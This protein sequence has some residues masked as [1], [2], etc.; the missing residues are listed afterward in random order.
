MIYA[1]I[2]WATRA[3]EVAVV[4]TRGERIARRAVSNSGAGLAELV[5]WLIGLAGEAGQVQVAIEVPHGAVVETLLERGIAVF[6]CNPKQLDR[7]RDRFSVPGAKDDSLD[8]L[9]LANSLRTDCHAFR[10]IRMDDADTIILREWSRMAD[11]LSAERTRLTNRLIEQLRR[12]FPQALSLTDDCGRAWFLD[13]M[14]AVPTPAK[15]AT[16]RA[17]VV[18]AIL[19]RHRIRKHSADSVLKALRVQSVQVAAGT[20]EAACAHIALLTQRLR[21]VSEQWTGA[22]KRI[23]ELLTPQGHVEPTDAEVLRSMPG[24]GV[25]ICGT[26]LG[27]AGALL[28]QRD[29]RALRALAGIAPVTRRSGKSRRVVMRKACHGRLRRAIY[30]W[31]RVAAQCDP[32]WKSRYAEYRARGHSHGRAYRGLGDRL[33]KVALAMLENRTLYDRSKFTMELQTA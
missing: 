19:K 28:A 32:H 7:F 24:L 26:L 8:A 9:V 27:E 1:G 23:E 16:V 25:L 17:R 18:A 29:Y 5:D 21:L 6:A 14:E 20:T 31:A 4:D 10:S 2:D 22:R 3:H 33:L 12:F 30:H 11:E 13:L 15:A